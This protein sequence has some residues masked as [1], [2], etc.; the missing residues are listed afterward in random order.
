ME[1]QRPADAVARV[2]D[3]YVSKG[4]LEGR[5]QSL[6]AGRQLEAAGGERLR[7][8]ALDELVE[9]RLVE[10]AAKE[11]GVDVSEEELDQMVA[12]SAT[13]R[14]GAEGLARFLD[15][16][17]MTQEDWRAENRFT[18]LRRKLRDERF[19]VALSEEEIQAYYVKYADAGNK[20]EKVRVS[21]I[22]LPVDPKAAE[23]QWKEAEQALSTVRSEIDAGLAFDEA[24]RRSSK[25]PYAKKG[26]DM[27]FA[28]HARRP[29]DVFAPAF[30]MKVGEIAGPMRVSK[31]VQL[32]KVT[33]RT[34]EKAGTFEQE[35]ENIRS[36]LEGQARQRNT[37]KLVD[38]LQKEYRVEYYL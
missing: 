31:G 14:G 27:G 8:R 17:A 11:A 18:A 19:P 36:V 15:K 12:A 25:C 7:R 26:G 23:E 10:L 4:E 13:T 22:F 29:E 2:G 9:R 5:I 3:L 33:E 21:R 35:K 28:T 20:G 16:Q 1:E 24:A 6:T 32:L 34:E 38:Q 37:R 30:G